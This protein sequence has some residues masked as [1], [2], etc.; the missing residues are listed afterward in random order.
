MEHLKTGRVPYLGLELTIH[1]IKSQ[2]HLVRQ[3]LFKRRSYFLPRFGRGGR[4]ETGQSL[5]QV[6][7]AI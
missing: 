6:M 2:I 7:K 5:S 1:V 3:S 4:R